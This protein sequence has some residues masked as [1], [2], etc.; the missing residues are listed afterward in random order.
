MT[1][2]APPPARPHRPLQ[3]D[4]RWLALVLVGGAVGTGIRDALERANPAP[5]G[6]WPWT[7]FVIN[8]TG[9]FVLAVLLES[10]ALGGPDAGWRRVLRL[11]VGTGV[12]GGFTT[13]STFAVE[14]A[15]L[16][17]ADPG[18]AHGAVLVGV[19]YA[20]GSVVLGVAAAWAGLALARRVLAGRAGGRA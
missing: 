12:L 9:S 8:V 2:D 20:V 4:P 11:G 1:A 7:T 17:G 6:G 16:L 14:T 18:G 15:H 5:A 19:G 3:R 10:L 13:Y